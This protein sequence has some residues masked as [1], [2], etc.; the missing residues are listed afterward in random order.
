MKA[1]STCINPVQE[2]MVPY[3]YAGPHEG[4]SIPVYVRT[5]SP[6]HRRETVILFTGLDGYRPDNTVRCEEFLARNWASVVVEILGTA[7]CPADPADPDAPERLWD[8]LLE[9]ASG[10]SNHIAFSG[11]MCRG[12]LALRGYHGSSDTVFWEGSQR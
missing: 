8:S 11:G 5:P 3:T 7:D 2:V 12:T 1:A 10:R 9:L 4:S 6:N